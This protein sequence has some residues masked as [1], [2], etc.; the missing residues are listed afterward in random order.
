[1]IIDGK[2]RKR[3]GRLL[4]DVDQA[5]RQVQAS[6]EYLVGEAARRAAAKQ[7]A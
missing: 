1:V 4:A 5:R 3:D 7:Q 2:V 6:S